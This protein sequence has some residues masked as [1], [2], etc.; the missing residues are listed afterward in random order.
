MP[1]VYVVQFQMKKLETGELVPRFDLEEAERFGELAFV[2]M[3][4]VSPFTP[5]P[6]IAEMYER[7]KNF[8]PEDFLLLIGNPC[9]I[10]WATAIVAHKTD[11]KFNMLQ[12][13]GETYRQ[14]KVDNFFLARDEGHGNKL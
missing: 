4:N 3:S 14:I 8:A 6:V 12:W 13:S 7:L 11:G 10:G 1:K 9:L 5:E 2:M